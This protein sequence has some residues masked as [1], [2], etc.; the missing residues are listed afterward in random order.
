MI[1]GSN[2]C[3]ES[4]IALVALRCFARESLMSEFDIGPSIAFLFGGI[5]LSGSSDGVLRNASQRRGEAQSS[6][7][8][9]TALGK[10][11]DPSQAPPPSVPSVDRFCLDGG[12]SHGHAVVTG[13]GPSLGT[14]RSALDEQR[15]AKCEARIKRKRQEQEP[16]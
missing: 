1:T 2:V 16:R 12:H 8:Q 5:L 15:A 4:L 9:Q 7:T 14:R 13:C 6:T 11:G 3:R 10:G